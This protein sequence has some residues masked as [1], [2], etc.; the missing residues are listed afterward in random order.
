MNKHIKT[1]FTG[2]NGKFLSCEKQTTKLFKQSWQFFLQITT[3]NEV[4][5]IWSTSACTRRLCKC[6]GSSCL[7]NIFYDFMV[8]R[9]WKGRYLYF[10]SKLVFLYFVKFIFK[11]DKHSAKQI[12]SISYNENFCLYV[13]CLSVCMYPNIS[14]ITAI[15]ALKQTPKIV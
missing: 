5:A 14:R 7:L 10:W 6:V 13:V 9:I 11:K 12:F 3:F 2:Y 4:K 1:S 8:K 15:T